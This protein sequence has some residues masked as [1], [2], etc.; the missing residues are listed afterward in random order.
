MLK[1]LHMKEYRNI[2][3]MNSQILLK[4]MHRTETIC[5]I[6]QMLVLLKPILLHAFI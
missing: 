5:L 3:K 4:S 1:Y 2:L 6:R